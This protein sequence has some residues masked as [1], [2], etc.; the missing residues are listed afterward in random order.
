M[1]VG[2]GASALGRGCAARIHACSATAWHDAAGHGTKVGDA[3]IKPQAPKP[4][5]PGLGVRFGA[6]T[7]QYV[8]EGVER[9]EAAG[10]LPA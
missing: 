3:W 1:G 5:L 2:E 4:L 7:R 8:L 9:V 6:S 10:A